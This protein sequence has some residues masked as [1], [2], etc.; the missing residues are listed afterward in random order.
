MTDTV[1]SSRIAR[2]VMSS[3]FPIGVD[4]TYKHPVVGFVCFILASMCLVFF[5]VGCQ[6]TTTAGV[7]G[8][9]YD[10]QVYNERNDPFVWGSRTSLVEEFIR[11][12]DL[13][14]Q[15]PVRIPSQAIHIQFDDWLPKENSIFDLEDS[16]YVEK[17]TE[18]VL[19]ALQAPLSTLERVNNLR[20]QDRGQHRAKVVLLSYIYQWINDC[21]NAVS[22]LCTHEPQTDSESAQWTER[23]WT[24]LDSPCAYRSLTTTITNNVTVQGWWDLAAIAVTSNSQHERATKFRGWQAQ[25]AQH[26]A[27]RFPPTVFKTQGTAPKKVALLLPQS[28]PLSIA[29]SAIKN[30]FL[31]AHL[32]A[33]DSNNL[34]IDVYDTATTEITTLIEQVVEDGVDVIV[35]PL[36]KEN[37]RRVLE[38]TTTS[39]PI[40]ALN[41][42]SRGPRLT[43][44]RNLV[45]LAQVVE[46]DAAAIAREI[47]AQNLERVLLILGDDYWCIRAAMSFRNTINPVVVVAAETV[48]SDLGESTESVA[49]L[50]R[51]TQSNTR[52]GDVATITRRSIEFTARRRQDV[53]AIV[54]FVDQDEFSALSAALHYHFAGDVPVFLAEPTFRDLSRAGSYADGVAFTSTPAHLYAIPLTTQIQESFADAS[55]LFPLYVFGIDAYRTTMHI[56][57]VIKGGPIYGYTGY[58]RQDVDKTLVRDP[59]WGVVDGR[60]LK[61]RKHIIVREERNR[62][63]F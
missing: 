16:N 8:G 33:T 11:R 14:H 37:V 36:E 1:E 62:Q 61:P 9:G 21:E 49:N 26:L 60:S 23:I 41:R 50:F 48:L 13:A 6:N 45:Q 15:L 59:V 4:T 18:F 43:P 63:L 17:L 54:A 7:P 25:Y 53:D 52:Q 38:K 2:T 35:G 46:D 31:S 10:G 39:V 29:A 44:K 3:K 24:V 34:S 32:Q 51:V 5:N 55:V 22:V 20:T 30:G 12:L 27:A 47:N 58:L 40:V 28:G 19:D 57:E 42:P 56:E